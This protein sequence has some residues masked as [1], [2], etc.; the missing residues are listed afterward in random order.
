LTN[1][2]RLGVCAVAL[3]IAFALVPSS[4]AHGPVNAREVEVLVLKDE[5]SDVQTSLAGYDLGEFYVAEAWIPGL[6]DGF[7]FHTILF[8]SFPGRPPAEE[9]EVVFTLEDTEG[10]KVTRRILTSD[11]TT[12][13]TDF[14]LLEA[15]AEPDQIEI[16]RAFIPFSTAGWKPGNTVKSFVVESFADGQLRDRAPGA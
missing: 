16:E 2:A 11:G 13:A 4:S 15:V 10:E 3:A 7:Y 9:Y 14:E 12:F 1:S 8:G 6:G 5:L